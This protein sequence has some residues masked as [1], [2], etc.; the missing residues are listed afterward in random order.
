MTDKEKEAIEYLKVRLY[1][2][3]GCK[4][5]DVSQEDLRIF[6]K[7]IDRKE[8]E[9]GSWKKYCNEQEEN[10]IE[11]SNI[12]CDL[13]FK[14]QKQQE[15]IGE[16]EKTL[17]IFNEREYRKRYLEE[18]RAKRKGLLYPDADEIYKRYYEQKAEIEK[19]DRQ[20]YEKTN[21]VN[22]LEKEC[23]KYFDAMMETIQDNNM[24]NRII[25][26][27]AQLIF[28]HR[29]SFEWWEVGNDIE[30]IKQQIE[31]FKNEVEKE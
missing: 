25:I 6:L 17:D 1:G 20:L 4:S 8:K 23:Q 3:E 31:Y 27:M 16:Y 14:I 9:I 12:I 19:K 15:E 30:N 11:K 10:I 29:N 21:R 24:K 5:I 7:L 26:K 13:E 28:T 2:N 18:E 22:N